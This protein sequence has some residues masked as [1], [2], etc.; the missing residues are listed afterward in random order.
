MGPL[1]NW[2]G[3]V[4][5][6]FQIHLF[7]MIEFKGIYNIEMIMEDFMHLPGVSFVE[8]NGSIGSKST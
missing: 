4:L 3:V 2:Y 7:V 1:L 6:L 8:L 5:I